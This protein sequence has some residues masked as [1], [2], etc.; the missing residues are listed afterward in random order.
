MCQCNFGLELVLLYLKFILFFCSAVDLG[1]LHPFFVTCYQ[2][3]KMLT[4][5]FLRHFEISGIQSSVLEL[6]DIF[7]L[8]FVMVRRHKYFSFFSVSLL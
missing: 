8:S 1:K 5:L 7:L 6:S 4:I 2:F 3:S